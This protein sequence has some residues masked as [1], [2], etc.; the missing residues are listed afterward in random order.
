MCTGADPG[1][2][3]ARVEAT[4]APS[5]LRSGGCPLP[6]RL[7]G[8]GSVVSSPSGVRG[9]APAANAFSAYSMPQNASGR[10]KKLSFSVKF[11]SI[12]Y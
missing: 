2:G 7:G 8:L 6:S 11:S 3:G 9:R 1:A 4:K 5:G 10:K 12:N